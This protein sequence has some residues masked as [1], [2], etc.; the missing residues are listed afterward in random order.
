VTVYEEE[1]SKYNGPPLLTPRTPYHVDY[2]PREVD[3]SLPF[4]KRVGSKLKLIGLD[5]GDY[6]LDII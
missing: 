1:D 5:F 4:F 3:K 6:I 2:T